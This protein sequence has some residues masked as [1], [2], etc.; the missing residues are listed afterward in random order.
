MLEENST[1]KCDTKL[2]VIVIILLQLYLRFR[3]SEINYKPQTLSWSYQ[4]LN[5]LHA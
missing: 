4:A 1:H 3:Q 2:P 5:N